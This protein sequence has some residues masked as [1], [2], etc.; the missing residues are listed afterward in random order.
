LG[1]K[2]EQKGFSAHL[3]VGRVKTARKKD[4]LLSVIDRFNNK[5]FTTQEVRSIVLKKSDLTPKGPI[6][7]TVREVH[8]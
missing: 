5:E 6:Y 4:Q 2:K 7:T 1:F 8:L 3:T